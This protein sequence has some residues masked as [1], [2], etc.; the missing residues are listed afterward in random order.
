[1]SPSKRVTT[2]EAILERLWSKGIEN[3]RRAL[4]VYI[5]CQ[6]LVPQEAHG[7]DPPGSVPGSP[8]PPRDE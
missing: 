3:D 2:L 7:T 5:R 6:E 8:K 4:A 1:M